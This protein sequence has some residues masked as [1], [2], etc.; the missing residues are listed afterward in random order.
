M[1]MKELFQE[2]ADL[3]KNNFMLKVNAEGKKKPTI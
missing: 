2:L 3:E 1:I